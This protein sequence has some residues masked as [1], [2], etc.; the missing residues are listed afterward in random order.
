M[1]DGTSFFPFRFLVKLQAPS[2]V[3]ES[4]VPELRPF[5]HIKP[6]F[7]IFEYVSNMFPLKT[8]TGGSWPIHDQL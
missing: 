3:G 1:A 6:I 5:R 7:E 4:V 2:L 8:S